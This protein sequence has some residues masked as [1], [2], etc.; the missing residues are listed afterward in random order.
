MPD[1]W[2]RRISPL[3]WKDDAAY[4]KSLQ[5]YIF[6][7]LALFF[8]SAIAG[9]LAAGSDPEL[10]ATYVK[11]IGGKLEWILDL[12]PPLMMLAIFANNLFAATISML[13]GIGFGIIP[14]V[15]AIINGAV[16]GIVVWHAMNVSGLA[17]VTIAILPHGIIELP[18]IFLSIGVGLRLGHLLFQTLQG[19]K[20]DLGGEMRSVL[21]LLKWIVL[22]LFLAAMIETF[23]TPVLVQPFIDSQS[24]PVME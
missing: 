1:S 16:I 10:A 12:S 3:S 11:E 2:V 24:L 5:N 21:S 13:L 15:I 14:A 8:G 23:I 22:L 19:K 7:A 6:L 17:F 18:T 9:F 20:V 4:V